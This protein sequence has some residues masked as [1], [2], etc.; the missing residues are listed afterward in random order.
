MSATIR[1]KGCGAVMQTDRKQDI[2]YAVSME[3]DYCQSCF[4][5]LHYGDSETHFHPEDLPALPEG[6]VIL[7]I[8]SVLHLDLLFSHPVWRYQSDASFIYIINQIDLLPKDTNLEKLLENITLKAK[9]LHVPYEDIILMSAKNPYDIN[10][11][12]E[13]LRTF[14]S[15]KIYLLGVQNS[16]KTT[17]FKAL[18][19]NDQA[20]AFKKAGL[21]QEALSGMFEDKEIIDMPGLYQKGYLHRLFPYQVYKRLI[22]DTEIHPKIYALKAG[23]TLFVEGLFAITLRQG[24]STLVLYIENHINVHKTQEKKIPEL[25]GQKTTFFKVY[26]DQYEEKALKIIDSKMQVTMADMGFLH[27]T[28]P[29]QIY[30]TYAKGLHVSL[31]EALFQ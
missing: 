3:H 20:L 21:T 16:G 25:L 4:R 6:S 30:L 19:Q 27:V 2:G 12:K 23:Q 14:R 13:Y 18:S 10:H 7:M 5:L 31:S 11:L 9:S 22:P 1:C 8:S 29:C 28:G 15:K 26:A 17:L 24:A